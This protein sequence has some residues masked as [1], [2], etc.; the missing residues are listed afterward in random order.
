MVVSEGGGVESGMRGVTRVARKAMARM[1]MRI[2]FA[3]STRDNLRRLCVCCEDVND[4][5]ASCGRMEVVSVRNIFEVKE[6]GQY[7]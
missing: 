1:V 7:L 2:M 3:D 4:S 5:K 6:E